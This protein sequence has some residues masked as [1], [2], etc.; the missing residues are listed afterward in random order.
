MSTVAIEF[1][2]AE[3]P[4]CGVEALEYFDRYLRPEESVEMCDCGVELEYTRVYCYQAVCDHCGEHVTEYGDWAAIG[5]TP[6]TR[7]G[8]LY[9]IGNTS[10]GV[11]CA[12]GAGSST[13]TTR[14]RKW[15]HEVRPMEA[16]LRTGADLKRTI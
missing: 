13:T 8:N 6:P 15:P 16:G 10:T 2:N 14:C 7:C 12:N 9:P 1:Q 5:P 11:T 4:M 3:C